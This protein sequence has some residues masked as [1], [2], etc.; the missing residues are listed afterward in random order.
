MNLICGPI[1][2]IDWWLNEW[3]KAP[4]YFLNT[5]NGKKHSL[6]VNGFLTEKEKNNEEKKKCSAVAT[7]IRTLIVW[8]SEPVLTTLYYFG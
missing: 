1:K 8:H 7:R 4:D 5:R 2:M 6:S 3:L